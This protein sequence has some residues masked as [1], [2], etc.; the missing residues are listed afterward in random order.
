[1]PLRLKYMPLVFVLSLFSTAG[2]QKISPELEE[3][4]SRTPPD[5]ARRVRSGISPTPCKRLFLGGH[6]SLRA[7]SQCLTALTM[8]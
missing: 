7:T 6:G 1:M 4:L 2:A 5:S 8:C 3:S